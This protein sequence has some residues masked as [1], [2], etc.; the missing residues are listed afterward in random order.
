MDSGQF[1]KDLFF[2]VKMLVVILKTCQKLLIVNHYILLEK[3]YKNV[4]NDIT[5]KN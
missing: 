2:S 3:E 4:F 5:F 1:L